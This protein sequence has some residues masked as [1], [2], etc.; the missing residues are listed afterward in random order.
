MRDLRDR[1]AVVTGSG[2]GI[3]R[4]IACELAQAGMH[5]VLADIA[6]DRLQAVQQEIAKGDR[7][8]HTVVTD[9]RERAQLER[10]LSVTLERYGRCDVMVNN[11]GVFHANSLLD[12]PVEQWK[13]V[14]D[15]NVWGVIHGSQVFGRHFVSRREGHIVNTASAAGL[16][17]A[18]GMSSYSTSKYAVFGFSKQLRWELAEHGVGVTTLCPG[19]VNTNIVAAEGVGLDRV[20]DAPTI[21]ALTARSPRPEGL[22]VKVRRAIERNQALVRYGSDAYLFTAMGM[23]PAWLSE[24]LG[25][26][27]ARTASALFRGEYKPRL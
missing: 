26:Y 27:M 7:A 4:A 10:L 3:G 13:R 19:V 18:V 20:L 14:I 25:R 11:A 1:V 2:S 15:T 24:P 6:Q 5:I 9:V 23:L 12:A 16:F 17:P 22:A 21:Q 8:P